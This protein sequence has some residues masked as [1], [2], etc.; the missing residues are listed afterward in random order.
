VRSEYSNIHQRAENLDLLYRWDGEKRRVLGDF[1]MPIRDN[2]Q[3]GLHFRGDLRDENWAIRNSFTG[4]AP[5]VA[6]FNL[7][8]RSASIQFLDV[9]SGRWSW[10]AEAELSHRGYRSVLEGILTP[11]PNLLADGAQL[12]QSLT[13]RANVLRW[14]ERRLT[15]DA[16][17]TASIARLWS[18]NGRSFSQISGAVRLHWFP[19]HSGQLYEVQETVRTGKTFGDPPFD[20]LGMV[21]VLGDTDLLMRA[22]IATRDGKKGSAPLGR[23]YFL[24][25]WEATRDVSPLALVKIKVG[26]FVDAGKISDPVSGLGSHEWLCD[27]GAQATVQVFGFGVSLSYGRD[28]RSGRNAVV[29]RPR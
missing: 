12:K 26:P 22:H 19:Q 16:D 7:K 25:T 29:A 10:S 1:R 18:G 2:P 15:I 27:L 11:T 4:P 21:G 17:G 9:S 23:N 5:L 24:S 28:L 20:E 6:A 3:W 8:R 13:G 14:P